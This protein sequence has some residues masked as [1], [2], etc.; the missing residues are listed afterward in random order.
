MEVTNQG[1][2]H[3]WGVRARCDIPAGVIVCMYSGE[4]MDVVLT[5]DR[6]KY[7]LECRW[8]NPK[9]E[10]PE[11]W[12]IDAQKLNTTAGRY[13][14]SPRGTGK[15]ANVTYCAGLRDPHPST[16]MY[17][18]SVKTLRPIRKG[19]ELL[20]SYGEDYWSGK[21]ILVYDF[22]HDETVMDRLIRLGS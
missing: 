3:G 18:V 2:V 12:F 9:T 10:K 5:T 8:F 21:P 17:Y 7:I 11:S 1:V 6:S 19:E 4:C 15:D 20:A 22:E 13:I 16:G 14:N